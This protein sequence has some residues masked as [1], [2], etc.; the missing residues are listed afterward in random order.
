MRG[1]LVLALVLAAS[2]IPVGSA[3]PSVQTERLYLVTAFGTGSEAPIVEILDE[4]GQVR[5]VVAK[6]GRA[7][8]LGA[9]W[10]PDGS[11]LAWIAHNG[12]S[13]ERVDGGGRKLLVPAS[14]GCKGVCTGFSFAWSPDGQSLAVG[15][16]GLETN[17]LLVVSARS[18]D[19]T[20]IAPASRFTNYFVIGWTPDG[21]SLVYERRSGSL[22]HAGCCRLDIRTADGD[23]GNM[24]V[25]YRFPDPFYKGSFPS[26]A[27]DGTAIAFMTP[28]D[29]GRKDLIRVVDLHSGTAHAIDLGVVYDQAPA[30]SPDSRKLAMSRLYGQVVTV[31]A[32][33]G[34]PRTLG[35]RGTGVSWTGRGGILIL[36][37]TS[38][39]DVWATREGATARRLF[40]VP[41]GLGVA[42]IDPS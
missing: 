15:G 7:P 38:G 5:R 22:G 28:S 13:V 4:S 18:G 23:G 19:A 35:I 1:F 36:R 42:T 12:L 34:Q 26:L 17:H 31:P 33:G 16:A 27:P 40:R 25:A 30:W 6:A 24:R 21:S 20:E 3:S 10:S 29:D 32:G 11:M 41:D 8:A 14:A 37:G 9:R 39:G 2:A